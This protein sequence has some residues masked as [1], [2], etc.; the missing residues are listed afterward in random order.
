MSAEVAAGELFD[1]TSARR[2]AVQVAAAGAELLLA[3]P[4]V[5][6]ERIEPARLA[7]IDAPPG[8]LVYGHA[9]RPGWRLRLFTPLP[10]DVAALLPAAARFGG[11]IDRLGL[12]RAALL[13][14]L[15]SAAVVALVISLP[16]WLGPLV[17]MGVEREIGDGLLGDLRQHSC[18]TPDSEAALTALAAELDPDR[19]PVKVQLVRMGL[20]NA[21][22]VPGG[23]VLLFDGLVQQ[24]KSPDELAGVIGHEIGHVRKR[25]V[26]QA[27]LREFGLSL[28]LR[29]SQTQLAGTLGQVA[30][31]RYSR[32]AE[33]EADTFARARMAAVDVSPADSGAFFERMAAKDPA[34]RS[35]PLS[36]FASHPD[37]E[38]RAGEFRAAVQ[39]GRHYRP[40]LSEAQFGAIRQACHDDKRKDE[41]LKW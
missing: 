22:A 37:P 20:V 21:A 30:E 6:E 10:P 3:G 16:S 29:G 11:W 41:G 36:W 38:L 9:D 27:M 7:F 19:P 4:E 33:A 34:P 31:M 40:A 13:A 17:P 2:H 24:A 12:G 8:A 1:G 26:M 5:P 32:G 18:S 25:H 14:G 28:V 23:R 39:P 15:A 35:G